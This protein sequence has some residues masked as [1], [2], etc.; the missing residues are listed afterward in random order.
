MVKSI[1]YTIFE[2]E[3]GYFGLAGTE[4][5]LLRTHLPCSETK[6][7]ESFFSSNL[8]PGQFEKNFSQ[9]TQKQII[10]YFKGG[11]VDFSPDLSLEIQGF[12]IFARQVYDACRKIKFGQTV[13][14]G[15]LAEKS[16]RAGAGR[17]IGRVMAQNWLPLIIPCHRVIRSDGKIGGFSAHGGIMLK[18]KLLLHEQNTMR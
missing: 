14:Y 15:Q 18:K 4:P 1:K 5:W 13:S 8:P 9:A 11:R 3:W 6:N 2:T 16:G 10:A 12:S 17:A 7:I